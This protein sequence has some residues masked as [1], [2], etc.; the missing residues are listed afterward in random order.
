MRAK[1]FKRDLCLAVCSVLPVP[2]PD[3]PKSEGS[4]EVEP[5]PIIF[6]VKGTG[7]QR[8]IF[9]VPPRV[10]NYPNSMN[11]SAKFPIRQIGMEATEDESFEEMMLRKRKVIRL[12]AKTKARIVSLV[13]KE[14]Q[15]AA[16]RTVFSFSHVR[17]YARNASGRPDFLLAKRRKSQ[18]SSNRT[19]RTRLL[20]GSRNFGSC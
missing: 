12:Q 5:E 10:S 20:C 16:S 17:R 14:T 2:E 13:R 1:C 11:M 8:L 3:P 19:G 15:L 7:T 18:V 4:I 6:V 9:G